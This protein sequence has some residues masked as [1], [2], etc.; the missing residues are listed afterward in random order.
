M[1]Q[2]YTITIHFINSDRD[3][4]QWKNVRRIQF[5]HVQNLIYRHLQAPEPQRRPT[6]AI[7][8]ESPY[9]ETQINNTQY[10]P[11]TRTRFHE[12]PGNIY[13]GML[14]YRFTVHIEPFY[15]E[16]LNVEINQDVYDIIVSYLNNQ[17]APYVGFKSRRR[18]GGAGSHAQFLCDSF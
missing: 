7:P 11:Y 9:M 3:P 10:G 12:I 17:D 16:I 18:N 5:V 15:D 14:P 4:L 2:F 8:E 6:R 13:L 1:N